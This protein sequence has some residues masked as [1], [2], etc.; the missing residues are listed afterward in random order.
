MAG[1]DTRVTNLEKAPKFSVS[2]GFSGTFGRLNLVQG[3]VGFDVDRLT[4]N[5]PQSA[6]NG[7]FRDGDVTTVDTGKDYNTGSL[8]FGVKASQLGTIG[9][10]VTVNDAYLNFGVGNFWDINAGRRLRHAGQRWRQRHPG[11]PEVQ[12]RLQRLQ[13]Q[14]Q[15]PGLPV[16]QQR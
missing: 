5:T 8:T 1:I 3:T 14:L 13:Q 16:Q 10:V 2:G 6:S 15:V 12:R 4:A 9:G 7:G 11:R